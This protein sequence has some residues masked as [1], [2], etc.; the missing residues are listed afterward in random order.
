MIR[1]KKDPPYFRVLNK[2]LQTSP[3]VFQPPTHRSHNIIRDADR[4]YDSIYKAITFKILCYR[5]VD[6]IQV[7]VIFKRELEEVFETI[8]VFFFQM[9]GSTTN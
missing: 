7:F 8:F 6:Q 4:S 3:F 9:G 5:A 1:T 2:A